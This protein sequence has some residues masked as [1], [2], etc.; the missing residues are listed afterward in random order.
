MNREH[1][2]QTGADAKLDVNS[3]PSG[4][5]GPPDCFRFQRSLMFLAVNIGGMYCGLD[6]LA[7]TRVDPLNQWD[8]G[9]PTLMVDSVGLLCNWI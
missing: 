5:E 9:N 3:H 1:Q 4:T 7:A 6:Q 8:F 2:N